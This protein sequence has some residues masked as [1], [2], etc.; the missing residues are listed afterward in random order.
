MKTETKQR[1]TA[2]EGIVQYTRYGVF[3]DVPRWWAG[4]RVRVTLIKN[5]G[6]KREG[7]EG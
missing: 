2:H 7:G 3:V 4:R 5:Q 1:Q 6:R